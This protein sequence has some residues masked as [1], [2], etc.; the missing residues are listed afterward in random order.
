[1]SI[2]IRR[3]KPGTV[4]TAACPECGHADL[5]HPSTANPALTACLACQL[6]RVITVEVTQE[7]PLDTPSEVG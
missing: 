4:M 2:C 6:A 3:P 7:S 5:L 1:M